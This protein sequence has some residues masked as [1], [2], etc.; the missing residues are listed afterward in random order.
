M[1]KFKG[2]SDEFELV[3]LFLKI[4]NLVMPTPENVIIPYPPFWILK[5]GKMKNNYFFYYLIPPTLLN[6]VA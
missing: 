5:S 6:R 2:C 3:S 1:L 4:D